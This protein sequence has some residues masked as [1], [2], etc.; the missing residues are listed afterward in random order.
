MDQ[1]TAGPISGRIEGNNESSNRGLCGLLVAAHE[2]VVFGFDAGC[3]KSF[4]TKCMVMLAQQRCL[5]DSTQ[6]CDSFGH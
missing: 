3:C 1:G 5:L 4:V 2:Q 6:R